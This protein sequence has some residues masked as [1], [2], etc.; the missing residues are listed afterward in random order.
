MNLDNFV[1]FLIGSIVTS[2]F[3]LVFSKSGRK[4]LK[5]LITGNISS[6][7]NEGKKNGRLDK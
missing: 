4:K 5:V 2:I 6:M 1:W 7:V 3:G